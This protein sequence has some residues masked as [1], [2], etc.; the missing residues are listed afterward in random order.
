MHPG[1][2][3]HARSHFKESLEGG[4]KALRLQLEEKLNRGSLVV[5]VALNANP[6]CALNFQELSA[7]FKS[8]A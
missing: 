8:P 1:E 4:M 7:A 2:V 5:F 6:S 3:C